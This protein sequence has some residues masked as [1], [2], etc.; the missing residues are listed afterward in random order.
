MSD[1]KATYIE[2]CYDDGVVE[3][4]SGNAAEQIMRWY[5]ACEV[6]NCI[7]GARYTGPNF[8]LK[9]AQCNCPMVSAGDATWISHVDDCPT[10]T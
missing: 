9:P 8:E 3:V 6:M 10:R 7:H 5:R 4:A 2:I 1:H